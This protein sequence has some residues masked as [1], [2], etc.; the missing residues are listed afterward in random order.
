MKS[1][2]ASEGLS[3][4]TEFE[5]AGIQFDLVILASIA[6]IEYSRFQRHYPNSA[7]ALV[8]SGLLK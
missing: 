3:G 7:M 8:L 4:K 6:L 1:L 2:H 5:R